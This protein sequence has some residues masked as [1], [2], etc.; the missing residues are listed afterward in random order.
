MS[1]D[2]Q[3]ASGASRLRANDPKPEAPVSPGLKAVGGAAGWVDERTGAAKGVGYL[4]KKVFPD[5]W[6]FMLGEIAMY[7]MIICLI[8]GAFLT[9]WFIP[10]AGH[11]VYDGSF[12]PLRGVSM[13]EAYASTLDISFDIRGTDPKPHDPIFREGVGRILADRLIVD[14]LDGAGPPEGARVR[15]ERIVEQ[16]LPEPHVAQEEVLPSVPVEIRREP[17]SQ[18]HEGL[19]R[20]LSW[21][22]L[23]EESKA[24][25]VGTD[26]HDFRHQAVDIA[27]VVKIAGSDAPGPESF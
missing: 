9:F 15:R 8:T 18:D 14:R 10:S 26:A 17:A 3:T 19:R 25:P 22:G 5:H 7:S 2:G 23:E 16:P 27:V 6:S 24:L 12:V 21:S 1:T 20:V 13:S 11:T 4:M